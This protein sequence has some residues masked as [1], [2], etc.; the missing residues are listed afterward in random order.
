MSD[1]R[2]RAKALFAVACRAADPGPALSAALARTP[3]P[4][5]DPG[6]RLFMVAVG[7]AAV[8]MA[9]RL[10][11]QAAGRVAAAI[12]VTNPEN[13][14]PVAGAVV[15]AAGHPVPDAAGA[16]AAEAVEALLHGAGAADRVVALTSGGGSALLPAPVDGVSLQDKAAVSRLLLA[17]G[18][19]SPR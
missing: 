16:R 4:R 1:L 9:E 5:P 11:Q 17:A 18:L 3:L 8:P 19:R 7:K 14:R 10:L 2:D 12:V 6:G 13:A 15:H